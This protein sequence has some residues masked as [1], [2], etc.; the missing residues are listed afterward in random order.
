M[1]YAKVKTPIRTALISTEPTG[2]GEP[3]KDL[4]DQ[5][6]TSGHEAWLAYSFNNFSNKFQAADQK[7][8]SE[9]GWWGEIFHDI[10][11]NGYRGIDDKGRLNINYISHAGTKWERHH[12]VWAPKNGWYVP[13]ADG[14]FVPET[15]VAF[16][17]VE[18]KKEAIKKLEAN[19]IP[20][21]QVSYFYRLDN[22]ENERF[23]G[24][25][26]DPG[27]DAYGRF[28]VYLDWPPSNSG[29]AWV[30][31]RPAYGNPEIVMEVDAVPAESKT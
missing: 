8:Y 18:D 20:K 1:S 31:S 27:W 24:R 14:I 7:R 28:R 9:R 4:F 2:W 26:F 11:R 6:D 19:G 21:E 25:V 23:A 16:E 22:Y 15:L 13:T 10:I 29:I 30:A 17:T 5:T 12:D 3:Y